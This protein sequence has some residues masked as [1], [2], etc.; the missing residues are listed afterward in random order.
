[1]MWLPAR[2]T[3]TAKLKNN[4]NKN[5]HS[6]SPS[7][8]TNRCVSLFVLDHVSVQASVVA[9]LRCV[10]PLLVWIRLAVSTQETRGEEQEEPD[11]P[12]STTSS[13]RHSEM[14][15]LGRR[16]GGVEK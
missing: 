6:K 9:V 15:E 1:M 12:L 4:N 7:F 2:R 3:S 8:S 16:G 5:T 11:P 10:L 14:G 13:S